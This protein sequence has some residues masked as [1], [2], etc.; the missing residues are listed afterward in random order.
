MF[1]IL[2]K[3]SR[4]FLILLN[5][6]F[7]ALFIAGCY[8]YAF[9]PVKY[10]FTGLLALGA[11]YLMLVV[12]FFLIFWLIVKPPLSL[13]SII[14]FVIVWSPA[15]NIFQFRFADDFTVKKSAGTLRIMN[16]NV[17]HFEIG[18][19][20][21]G[22]ATKKK[23]LQLI[24]KYQPDIA[25]FQ[26]MVGSETNPKA[27]N[28]I[29]YFRDTLGFS[30]YYFTYNNKLDYDDDHHFGVIV[31]S[32]YPIIHKMD[33]AFPPYDYNSTYQ[34]VDIKVGGDTIRTFNVHLQS[35]KFD[36]EN[37]NY[38]EQPGITGEE[39]IRNSKS[40]IGKLKTGFMLRAKQ[41]DRI[42]ASIDQSPYPV[43]VCGDFNDVPNSYAYSTIGEGLQNAFRKRGSGIGR[44]YSG[45]APTLRIDHV[46]L[47]KDF[48]LNQYTRIHKKMSDHYPIIVDVELRK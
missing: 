29:P 35:L 21:E 32:K 40:I 18:N 3:I 44:T 36:K 2:R 30:D 39:N 47:D 6:V 4:N 43:V 37:R 42:K 34:L 12:L 19:K 41:S 38:L 46:F 45:I 28:Y 24:R 9:D 48:N 8:A 26:E 1:R 17:E 22:A 14:T 27:L 16:W 13:L 5:V 11:F 23:M 10:W 25:F 7:S 20:K 15:Q 31:F 33:V